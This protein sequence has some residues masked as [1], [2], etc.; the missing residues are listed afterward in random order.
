MT[1]KCQTPFDALDQ[2]NMTN[3]LQS[4]TQYVLRAKGIVAS[5]YLHLKNLPVSYSDSEWK[6]DFQVYEA[7]MVL[8]IPNHIIHNDLQDGFHLLSFMSKK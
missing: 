5:S 2:P 4:V 1:E 8:S 7:F 3:I 6:I